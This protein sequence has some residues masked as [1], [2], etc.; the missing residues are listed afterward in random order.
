MFKAP[1]NSNGHRR[2]GGRDYGAHQHREDADQ[3]GVEITLVTAGDHKADGNPYQSLPKEVREKWQSEAES[4]RQ[5]FAGKA[6][7]Y[8]DVDIKTILSTEAQVYEGQAA[9]DAG[10]ANEV[11][12]GL[13]AV[14]IMTE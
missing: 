2:L 11:V 12:N 7:E 8:M 1:N 5:M 13:D 6:A 4:T 10:F 14:Q 3:Q 9:V